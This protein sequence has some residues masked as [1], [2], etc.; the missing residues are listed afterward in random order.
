MLLNINYVVR[1]NSKVT[2]DFIL[3]SINFRLWESNPITARHIWHSNF[4]EY[5]IFIC[6][7][8]NTIKK[9]LCMSKEISKN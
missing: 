6:D 7:Q 4:N 3:K 8:Y 9:L 1:L 5:K 2:K